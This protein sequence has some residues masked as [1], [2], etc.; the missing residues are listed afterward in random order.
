MIFSNKPTTA[1][2]NFFAL[3]V[4]YSEVGFRIWFQTPQ[5]IF[6][7]S[8]TKHISPLLRSMFLIKMILLSAVYSYVFCTDFFVNW[9]VNQLQTWVQKWQNKVLRIGMGRAWNIIYCI[10]SAP[11][12]LLL[13]LSSAIFPSLSVCKGLV[14]PDQIP[15][16]FQFIK[17]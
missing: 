17:A 14:T 1:S 13:L 5:K 15:N 11:L 8:W 16:F 10:T 3:N 7:P 6:P 2:L 4:S 12:P 9:F